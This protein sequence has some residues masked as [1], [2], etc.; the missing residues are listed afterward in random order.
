MAIPALIVAS[1]SPLCP[2]CRGRSSLFVS[3]HAVV[4]AALII[5]ILL[6]VLLVL[7]VL[8]V[9][10]ALLVLV[11]TC[12]APIN[13]Q[14]AHQPTLTLHLM[15][16]LYATNTTNATNN[17]NVGNISINVTEKHFY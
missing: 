5:R 11:N 9:L 3:R 8:V 14:T 17:T 10:V 6:L 7:L 1:T 15:Q 16:Y 2:R 12:G 4:L 13:A